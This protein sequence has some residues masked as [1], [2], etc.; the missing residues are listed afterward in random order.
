VFRKERT[1]YSPP[2]VC[3]SFVALSVIESTAAGGID[4]AIGS[5]SGV[6]A[7]EMTIEKTVGDV[8]KGDEYLGVA[9]ED[10]LTG[11]AAA[12]FPRLLYTLGLGGITTAIL[13]ANKHLSRSSILWRSFVVVQCHGDVM[14]IVNRLKKYETEAGLIT[15]N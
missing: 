11:E 14:N 3:L 8:P 5:S 15:V 1:N 6:N 2:W 7:S 9:N 10:A 13:G 12:E 4:F